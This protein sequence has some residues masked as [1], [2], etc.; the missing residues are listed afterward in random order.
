MTRFRWAIALL[1]ALAAGNASP[2]R[3]DDSTV[4]GR[5]ARALAPGAWVELPSEGYDFGK[6]MR[7]EDILAY[8]GKAAWDR[9]SQQVLFIGQVHLKGPPVF[10]TYTAKTNRWQQMPTPKWAEALKWFHAYE[11]NAA[12]SERGV[13]YHHSSASPLVHRYDVARG[14]WSTL[15]ELK[16]AGTGHGTAIEYFP[17]MKGLVRFLGGEVWFFSDARNTWTR[18]GSKLAAG[19]YH[20]FAAYS[21]GAKAVLLGGGNNSG[22][23]HRLTADGKVT[24]GAKAPLDLGI[25]RTLTVTDPASGALLVLARGKFLAYDPVKDGWRELPTKDVPFPKYDGHSVSAVPLSNYG[26]VLY[27]ASR[28]Q[29]MK[30]YLYKHADAG[31]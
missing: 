5:L 22:A 4:V 25:G 10:I 7:G 20:N 9:T 15:P 18:L 24:A 30:T 31:R 11:N 26:V 8:A 16:G 21:P 14:E 17:D 3:A 2:V 23:V 19:P 13:F 12:D 29:G 6:L 1:L 28:P 27:F